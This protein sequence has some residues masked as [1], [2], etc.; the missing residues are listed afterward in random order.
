MD[1]MSLT[2]LALVPLV[3]RGAAARRLVAHVDGATASVQTVVLTGLPAAGGTR[4]ALRTSTGWYPWNSRC[5][6][7]KT[8]PAVLTPAADFTQDEGSRERFETFDM[9]NIVLGLR[10]HLH[11][12][13]CTCL[14][15]YSSPCTG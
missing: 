8:P 15:S 5:E 3:L 4:E 11:A 14:R 1:K 12:K 13:Q 9:R 2:V 6:D 7:L 10:P